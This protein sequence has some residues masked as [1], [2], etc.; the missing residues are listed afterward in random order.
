MIIPARSANKRKINFEPGCKSMSLVKWL[1]NPFPKISSKTKAIIITKNKANISANLSKTMVEI[2][3]LMGTS[4][5]FFKINALETSPN[6]GTAKFTRYPMFNAKNKELDF[7][8]NPPCLYNKPHRQ[9]LIKTTDT[10]TNKTGINTR[11]LP[12]L[13]TSKISENETFEKVK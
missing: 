11:K 2:D 10:E 13:I 12:V 6:L 1:N 9:T 7:N 8:S 5:L 3:W 4:S